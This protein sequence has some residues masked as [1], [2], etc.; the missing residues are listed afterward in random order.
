MDWKYNPQRSRNVFDPKSNEPF[1]LSRSRLELF[2]GCPRC[3][4]IDR[5]LGTDRPPG[6]PFTLNAA[7][8]TLLKKE[9]DIH[10][11]E[12]SQHPLMKEYG[13]DAVPYPGDQMD[14]WRENFKGVQFLHRPTNLVITGAVDDI[15]IN[16][17][18]ELMVVDYKA[19]STESEITL[20]AE[21]RQGYKRQ[22][23]IYQ[24]LLRQ[25]GYPVSDT[26]YFVYA[27]GK[28]DRKAFDKKLEFDVQ[29][30]SYTG[31]D[32][33]VEDIIKKA[34]ACLMGSEIPEAGKSCE[35]CAYRN[36]ARKHEQEGAS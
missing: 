18:K 34:H 16:P 17:K 19:T 9:F 3:F 35:Y 23:E 6:F 29:I 28:K 31:D 4:Y 24:W 15:W 33:W 22:M 5:R 26:G 13:I 7:V 30:I 25:N 11:A 27:N 12:G 14:E 32:S 21:Y 20:D 10:R 8:D 36:A 1:R 2:H